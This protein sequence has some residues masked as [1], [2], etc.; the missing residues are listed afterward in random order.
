M[1]SR[2]KGQQPQRSSTAEHTQQGKRPTH[3]EQER[4]GGA[5][6]IALLHRD[7]VP[8]H[9]CHAL[10][11]LAAVALAQQAHQLQRGR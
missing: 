8:H 1:P 11:G 2:T 3:L 6:G 5:D 4:G 10:A 9:V 7:G